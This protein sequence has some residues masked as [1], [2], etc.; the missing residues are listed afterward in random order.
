MGVKSVIKKAASSTIN[1]VVTCQSA[2]SKI[3]IQA[4][5]IFRKSTF[6]LN[7]Q[8]TRPMWVEFVGILYRWS[9]WVSYMGGV[10]GCPI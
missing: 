2:N 7:A 8:N 6:T 1:D 10:C 3:K 9:L 4:S 5:V